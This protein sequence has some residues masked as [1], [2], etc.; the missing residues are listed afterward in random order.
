MQGM[1]QDQCLV[2]SI[3]RYLSFLLLPDNNTACLFAVT[4]R[5]G[6]SCYDLVKAISDLQQVV[7]RSLISYFACN[8]LTTT[9][10]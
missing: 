5:S 7:P 6:I 2:F 9:S 8:K 10:S 3:F 1:I 4:E